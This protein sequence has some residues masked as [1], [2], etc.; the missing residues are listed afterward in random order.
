M[1]MYPSFFETLALSSQVLDS[2][3]DSSVSGLKSAVEK[4]VA[5]LQEHDLLSGETLGQI[6]D[7]VSKKLN[8]QSDELEKDARQQVIA[9]TDCRCGLMDVFDT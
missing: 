7:S 5:E 6:F 1:E 9:L 4:A 2:T 3:A 8:S